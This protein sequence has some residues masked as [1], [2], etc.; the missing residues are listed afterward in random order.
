MT[1][2]HLIRH[3]EVHN[4]DNVLYLRLPGMYLSEH[5]HHEARTAARVL[6]ERPI[7]AVYSSPMPR[8]VQT[9]DY[10]ASAHDLTLQTSALINELHSP[11]QGWTMDRIERMGWDL[12]SDLPPGYERWKDVLA[13]VMRFCR[14]ICVQH[15]RAEIVA[16][17]HGD[18]VITAAL[19]AERLPLKL[20][21]RARIPYPDHCSI[22]SLVFATP[23]ARPRR[24]YNDLAGVDATD[25]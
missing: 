6:A 15:P 8:A 12:Y 5:G 9:A 22:T 10:I 11:Y 4:P 19:W 16:A 25:N 2:I 14:Q 13:R 1:I 17:T 21:S 24:Y 23:D 18:I 20:A 3:G 7:E